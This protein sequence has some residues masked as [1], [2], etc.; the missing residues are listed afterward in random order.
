MALSWV[1]MDVCWIQIGE[2]KDISSPIDGRAKKERPVVLVSEEPLW[3]ECPGVRPKFR[4]F[5]AC[6]YQ[7][8]E[9]LGCLAYKS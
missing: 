6:N 5:H 4:T 2:F 9:V 3:V 7:T 8:N 1:R